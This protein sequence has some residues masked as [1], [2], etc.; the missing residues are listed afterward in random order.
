MEI[1]SR[2]PFLEG[3]VIMKTNNEY[4]IFVGNDAYTM[5]ETGNLKKVITKKN[6]AMKILVITIINMAFIGI[7]LFTIP[8][9]PVL[10][11]IM[12]ITGVVVSIVATKE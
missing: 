8:L 3:V 5:D 11:I 12:L 10:S 4:K 2:A 9:N 1:I 7:G 6:I